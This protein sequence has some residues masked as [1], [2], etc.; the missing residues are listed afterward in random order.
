MRTPKPIEFNIGDIIQSK[1]NPTKGWTFLVVDKRYR[2]EV[3]WGESHF[4]YTVYSFD[5]D[6]YWPIFRNH[7]TQHWKILA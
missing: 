1:R 7:T 6:D 2:E 5:K 3:I 4:L